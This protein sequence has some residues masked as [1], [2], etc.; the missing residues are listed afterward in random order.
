MNINTAAT[1][2]V[3]GAVRHVLAQARFIDVGD[4]DLLRLGP[5]IAAWSEADLEAFRRDL[6]ALPPSSGAE[7]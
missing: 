4:G 1:R 5:L 7:R 3:I 2:H 6:D